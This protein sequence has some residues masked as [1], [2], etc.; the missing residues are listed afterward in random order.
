MGHASHDWPEIHGYCV[1]CLIEKVQRLDLQLAEE[2]KLSQGY[3]DEAAKGWGKFRA[4]ELQIDEE[5]KRADGFLERLRVEGEIAA[6]TEKEIK[7]LRLQLSE[8]Q[9]RY[10][11]LAEEWRITDPRNTIGPLWVSGWNEACHK[12]AESVRGRDDRVQSE[13]RKCPSTYTH[14]TYGKLLCEKDEAHLHRQGDVEHT[15]DGVKWMSV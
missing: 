2:K 6:A 13:K 11:K 14:T 10:A 9:E 7:G 1:P 12:I 4:A 5:R 15:R 3:Y 8:A